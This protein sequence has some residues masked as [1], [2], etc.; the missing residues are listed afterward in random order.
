LKFNNISTHSLDDPTSNSLLL[1]YR[2]EKLKSGSGTIKHS[3]DNARYRNLK[4]A[5]GD[6]IIS[7]EG[8]NLPVS[9]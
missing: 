7:F 4:A 3:C 1:E 5:F 8:W 2:Q 9:M 6:R